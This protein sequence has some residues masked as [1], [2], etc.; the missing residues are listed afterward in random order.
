MNK[1]DHFTVGEGAGLHGSAAEDIS[2]WMQTMEESFPLRSDPNAF[3]EWQAVL[4]DAWSSLE[5]SVENP[6]F[7]EALATRRA[8]HTAA[9]TQTSVKQ[10]S[11]TSWKWLLDHPQVEQRTPE[12]Y[13]EARDLLTASE[14][15]DLWK[16]PGT[17]AA[18]V[19]KKAKEQIL[20]GPAPRH[21]V[22]RQET[23]A[24]L[25]GQR[26]EPVVKRILEEQT[27]STILEL[28]RIRHRSIARLAASPDGLYTEG[29]FAGRLVEIKCP[30][31]RVIEE[32]KVPQGYWCQMQLQM[33]V[34]DRP[35]CE[36]VEAKF[37][38]A[39]AVATVENPVATGY[40]SLL[41]HTDTFEN[42]YV[43]HSSLTDVPVPE[44]P[45]VVYETYPWACITLRRVNILRDREWFE[46]AKPMIEQFWSDVEGAR[47]GTWQPP[48]SR[49]RKKKEAPD[50][51]VCAI[52]DEEPGNNPSAPE[53]RSVALVGLEEPPEPTFYTD[54]QTTGAVL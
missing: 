25:W 30:P 1:S 36:Y 27:K 49:P 22:P 35:I 44:Q 29:E 38:E 32:G 40:I 53:P 9:F 47:N 46:Q 42:Q 28:G 52:V 19:M 13:A 6:T 43:Y 7:Q 41:T 15:G 5:F 11:D 12:W 16:G 8:F 39:D 23:N 24:M 50:P 4:H 33:E 17:R 14:I 45:W 26:Y 51:L 54:S 18:V 31:S 3:E 2:E 48:Q 37:V 21:C 10:E 20:G 34:C